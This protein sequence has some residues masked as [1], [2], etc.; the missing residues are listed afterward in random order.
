MDTEIFSWFAKERGVFLSKLNFEELRK[1]GFK[2]DNRISE[3]WNIGKCK[4]GKKPWVMRSKN[5]TVIG[6]DCCLDSRSVAVSLNPE[7]EPIPLTQAVSYWESL[8]HV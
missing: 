4:C 8:N 7:E 6:C 3:E 5:A 1:I 2:E